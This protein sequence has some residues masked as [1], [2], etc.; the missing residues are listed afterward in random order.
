MCSPAFHHIDRCFYNKD[1]V[2]GESETEYVDR[3]LKSYED[4]IARLAPSKIAALI[5]EPVTGATIGT[6][7]PPAGYLNRVRE[8]CDRIGALLIYDEVMCG[9]G[10]TGSYHAWEGLDGVSCA[11]DLQAIGKGLAAGYQPLSA[12][13]INEK[14]YKTVSTPGGLPFTN[15]HTYQGHA[16]ACGTALAVQ[17]IIVEDDLLSNVRRQG[18]RL[19]QGLRSALDP[20]VVSE[21]RGRGLFQTVEL[22]N[23][24]KKIAATV[25]ELCFQKGLAVYLVSGGIDGILF[26][27]PFIITDSEV[28]ALVSIFSSA[29]EEA[30]R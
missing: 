17:N 16:M 12:V 3:L 9:M 7:V 1:A 19:V 8:L 26:A 13:L 15:G 28:D 14:V 27:P 18:E 29:V 22:E 6:V 5:L 25:A 24:G 4:V 30:C 11:P 10:R 20:K 21:I 23:Q 2:E